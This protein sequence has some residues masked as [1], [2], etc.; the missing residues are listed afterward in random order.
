MG[1]SSTA[2]GLLEVV[3]TA[4]TT[5]HRPSAQA[6]MA[7]ALQVLGLRV[8]EVPGGFDYLLGVCMV[9]HR[10]GF[11]G[12]RPGPSGCVSPDQTADS[13]PSGFVKPPRHSAQTDADAGH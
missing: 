5:Q 9:R 7:K 13:T 4:L 8:E 6:V 10:G 12:A 3:L 1:W 11:L 2:P